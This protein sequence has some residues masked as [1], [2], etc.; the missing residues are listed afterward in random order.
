MI[1][2]ENEKNDKGHR[3]VELCRFADLNT[4][5]NTI[6]FMCSHGDNT[7]GDS[8]HGGSTHGNNTHGD[9]T[10]GDSTLKN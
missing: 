8:T 3:T 1:E 4:L 9:S 6:K 7:H 10:H 2:G 5:L